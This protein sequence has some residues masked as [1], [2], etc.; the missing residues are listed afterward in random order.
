MLYLGIMTLIRQ[1]NVVPVKSIYFVK[2]EEKSGL[3]SHL[4]TGD[5]ILWEI[6]SERGDTN[7]LTAGYRRHK[8]NGVPFFSP[9][10]CQ[11]KGRNGGNGVYVPETCLIDRSL[12]LLDYLV[13]Q[14]L[15]TI[16]V[17]QWKIKYIN[18]QKITIMYKCVR[19]ISLLCI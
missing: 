13:V 11:S 7:C 19:H 10:S 18:L 14:S 8:K 4:F 1:H 12:F 6:L 9:N 5:P 3:P 17:H 16:L 2:T 15:G